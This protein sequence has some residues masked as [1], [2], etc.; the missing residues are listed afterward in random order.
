MVSACEWSNLTSVST[1]SFLCSKLR[2]WASYDLSLVQDYRRSPKCRL[3]FDYTHDKCRSPQGGRGLKFFGRDGA[4]VA[5]HVA[6]RK[7]SAD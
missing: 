1:A 7:G 4:L 3:L 2:M 6:P 5:A